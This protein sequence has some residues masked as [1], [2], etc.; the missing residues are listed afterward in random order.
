MNIRNATMND[1]PALQQLLGDYDRSIYGQ[2]ET[3]KADILNILQA[4][5]IERFS[6]VV[7]EEERLIAFSGITQKGNSEFPSILIV[8]PEA[9]NRGIES[10]LLNSMVSSVEEGTL[11]FSSNTPYEHAQFEG[12]GFEAIRYWFRME[13]D[14]QEAVIGQYH[15][16][17][18]FAIESFKVGQDESDTYLA[19]EDAFQTHFGYTSSSLES[20]V[21]RTEREGFDANN[22]LLLKEGEEIAGFIFCQKSVEGQAEITHVGVRPKWRKKGFGK[23]LLNEAFLLQKNNGRPKVYLN[24]DSNNPSGA[25]QLYEDM[26]MKMSSH[27]VRYDRIIGKKQSETLGS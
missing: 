26:G 3:T 19:F 1:L 15:L 14:L 9:Q 17:P 21:K 10:D 23:V 4:I 27:F 16:P 22:W 18:N 13:I 24:V 2:V 20:F 7:V 8:H 5:E 25:V 12:M 11:I 6:W